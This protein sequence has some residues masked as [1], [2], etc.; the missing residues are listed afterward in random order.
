[1]SEHVVLRG[2]AGQEFE[3]G[4]VYYSQATGSHGVS[5]YLWDR[6][7][8]GGYESGPLGYPTSD[9]IALS[10]GS[11]QL[12]QGGT[13]YWSP[14]TG[15]HAVGGGIGSAWAA[16]G[17]ENGRLGYPTSDEIPLRGGVAQLFQG[18]TMY[19]SPGAG[20][21]AVSGAVRDVWAGQGW[22][23]GRLGYPVSGQVLMSS[24]LYWQQ[25]QGGSIEVAP[26][27]ARPRI[28]YRR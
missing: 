26:T 22:E 10:G 17:W 13:L 1:V 27:G 12:F 16:Q 28:T 9:E 18:G 6:Y 14:D 5:G 19:W 25:F 2:G 3:D 15:A 11:A 21:H 24:G 20:A 4:A 8:A 7:I 23:N